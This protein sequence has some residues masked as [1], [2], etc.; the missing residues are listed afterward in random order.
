MYL[1]L[2][3]ALHIFNSCKKKRNFEI[4]NDRFS[5]SNVNETVIVIC[6]FVVIIV[7]ISEIYISDVN[8]FF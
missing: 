4:C 6:E 8:V 3:K 7:N 2:L 5:C 1:I